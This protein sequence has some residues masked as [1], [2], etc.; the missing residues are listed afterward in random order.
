MSRKMSGAS[1][2]FETLLSFA[3]LLADRSAEA[4]L[5]YF[6]KRIAVANKADGA[7][8]DP[9]TAADRKAEKVIS[10][11]VREAFPDHGLEGEEFG[12]HQHSARH[13]WVIDPIDGTRAFIMGQPLWGTLIGLMRDGAPYLGIMDQPFTGERFWSAHKAA[14]ASVRGA[15]PVRLKSRPCAR[16]SD[17]IITT[18]HPDLFERG[19]EAN[20]F[21]K[22][23]S[24][25][26]MTRYGGD[27]YNY[28]LVAAGFVDL[29]IETGLKPYDVAALIPIIERAGGRMTAWDGSS[30]AQGGRVVASGDPK[31]HDWVLKQLAG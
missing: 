30:A 1:P 5:P 26:R 11:L 31:F 13:R 10:M 27:C 25:A 19:L 2:G 15:K 20:A 7:N 23:K 16:L 24:G 3:H 29:V 4:T 8:F 21:A 18:T 12:N 9:V 22:L 17:A 6:R 28:C 14:Y